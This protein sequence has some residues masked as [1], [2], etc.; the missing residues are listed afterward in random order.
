MRLYALALLCSLTAAAT[1][2]SACSCA[3]E[4][5]IVSL[6]E[7]HGFK[8]RQASAFH[9]RV[10]RWIGPK[11]V[12][13]EVVEAFTPFGGMRHLVATPG[14]EEKCGG[15]FSPNESF[16]YLPLPDDLIDFCSKLSATTDNLTRLRKA[17]KRA[18]K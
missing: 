7:V 17:S 16:I 4:E 2:A 3:S 10:V 5:R 6:I 14:P 12:E 15:S 1:P 18:A 11:E 13:V 9:G 8:G